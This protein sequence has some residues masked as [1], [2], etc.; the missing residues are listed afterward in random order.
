MNPK[1]E[2]LLAEKETLLSKISTYEERIQKMKNR[3]SE[4]DSKV[5]S[6]VNSEYGEIIE[7]YHMTPEQLAELL[8]TMK[9]KGKNE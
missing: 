7:A 3:I 9:T 1:K 2:K 5:K 6:I 8:Q 4:I